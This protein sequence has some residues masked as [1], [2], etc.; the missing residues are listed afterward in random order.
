MIQD[1]KREELLAF[2]RKLY[3]LNCGPR[4]AYNRAVMYGLRTDIDLGFLKGREIIQ[5]A[6]GV[7]QIIFG[8]DDDVR[9]SVEGEFSYFDGQ[10]GSVWRPE[11]GGAQIASRTLSLLGA[12]I[13]TF[14]G[15][16]NGT[17]TLTFSNGHRLTILDNSKEYE[18]YDITRPGETIVV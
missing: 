8:F 15:E 14:T 13:E 1:V 12:T 9:I 18:S 3:E 10:S 4:T 11:P 16:E 2:I 17:L 6:I 7:Y 5:V